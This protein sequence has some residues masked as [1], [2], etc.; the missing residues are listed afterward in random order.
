M[1][2]LDL[3]AKAS[4][5]RQNFS[6]YVDIVI[7]D[8]PVFVARHRHLFAWFNPE[9]IAMLLDGVTFH[10]EVDVDENGEYIATVQEIDDL[11]VRGETR[12]TALRNMAKLMA[13]YAEE[14]LTSSF[15]LFFNA[16]NRRS[17]FPLVLKIALQDSLDGVV[18]LLDVGH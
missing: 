12:E 5:V 16:P 1:L 17:H 14:Y 15:K 11:V 18:R 7:H 10:T 13:D 3:A 8:H 6:E 2:M 4:D 9:Q